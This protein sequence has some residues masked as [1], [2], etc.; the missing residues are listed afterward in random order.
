ML[1]NIKNRFLSLSFAERGLA[2]LAG[3]CL[4]YATYFAWRY[5]QQ[6]PLDMYN[7]RQSQTA[8][9]A[10]WLARDGFKLAYETP[11]AGMPWSIPFEFPL[12]QYLAALL[13]RMTSLPL[14]A[15]GRL[16]SFV[17]LVL[18]LLPVRA[19]TRQ[20]K[21]GDA[22][23][24]VF[25]ALLSSSPVYLY[26]GRTFM[27]ETTG[28]FFAVAALKY[29]LDLLA[30]PGS[31]RSGVLF[32]ICITLSILQ[33]ATTGLPMLAILGIVYLLVSLRALFDRSAQTPQSHLRFYAPRVGFALLYV[34]L[35][36]LIGML[37]T[38]YTDQ[39]KGLS[40]VGKLLTSSAL[41][42]WNWGSL[43]QRTTSELYVKVL[44]GRMALQNMG[45]LLGMAVLLLALLSDLPRMVKYALCGALAMGLLPFFLFTNL[46][47]VHTYYQSANALFLL[48]GLALALARLAQRF[49]PQ[50]AAVLLLALMMVGSN[51]YW[52]A[53]EY[54]PAA[55]AVFNRENSRDYDIGM[56]LKQ[57]M[58]ADKA[59]VGYGNDW[60]S[61]WAYMAERK[62]FTVPAFFS[63]YDKLADNPENFIP[64]A[65]LGGVVLC[66]DGAQRPTVNELSRWVYHR[67]A[68][69]MA[70]VHGCYV[71]LP[72]TLVVPSDHPP[73]IVQCEGGF[74]RT[75][76]AVNGDLEMFA[77]A[78]WA[79][80]AGEAPDA[81]Q[82][83]L[84]TLGKDGEPM[85]YF[86]AVE[87]AR[88][89][90]SAPAPGARRGF[91]MMFNT[92]QISGKYRVGV[93]RVRDGVLE[94]CQFGQDAPVNMK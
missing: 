64:A 38:S 93:A 72:K 55:K 35:P 85:R 46:H 51:Y 34:I 27:I 88:A 91:A 52:F 26:W 33:K 16:L 71:A 75:D 36:L 58:P 7:F 29:F 65:D 67:P 3:L 94:A 20:L 90:G 74:D 8:L 81:R 21:L 50:R 45:G 60:S 66:S 28:L 78:G 4:G 54:A 76:N 24:Y 32:F 48:F 57:Q 84:V 15:A 70:M 5:A 89:A 59:F 79:R 86:E 37:W 83:L 17:F 30:D 42:G 13:S 12:Y 49:F 63:N 31:R 1:Q 53:Q 9:S 43:E 47:I 25:T 11:V 6:A 73:R 82:T 22:T 19:I 61:T 23:F 80:F 69:K 39:V 40:P 92:W 41:K 44:W 18:C 10:F 2:L 68:W 77:V 56:T 14:D 62:S 87:T